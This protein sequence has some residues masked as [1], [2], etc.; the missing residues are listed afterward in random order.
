MS[1]EP[2]VIGVS[3]AGVVTALTFGV[4]FVN[5]LLGTPSRTVGT[6]LQVFATPPNTFVFYGRAREPGNSGIPG[7]RVVE[8]MTSQSREAD[9]DDEYQFPGLTTAR[10]R[11]EKDGFEPVVVT[12]SSQTSGTGIY[13]EAAMQRI[14]R[15]NAGE[16]VSDLHLAP[17]DLTYTV[18]SDRCFPCKL[19]RVM[20]STTGTLRL[21][22]AWTG[23]PNSLHIWV[24]GDRYAPTVSSVSAETSVR[25]GEVLVYVGWNLTGGQAQGSYV[26]FSLTS[27]LGA[28]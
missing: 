24:N 6:G 21:N 11:F 26:T 28:S 2:S 22:A 14:V 27:S 3:S 13:V 23:S 19:I 15:L 4:P 17:H 25:S 5:V 1:R 20:A 10:F 9:P 12:P 8:T 18:G 7:V 16:S